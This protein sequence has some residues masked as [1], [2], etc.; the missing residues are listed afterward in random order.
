MTVNTR[1]VRYIKMHSQAGGAI[2]GRHPKSEK[3][4]RRRG[5]YIKMHSQA[6]GA[7]RERH[8]KSEKLPSREPSARGGAEK[9][10]GGLYL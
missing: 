5:R 1:A 4:R 7:I 10:G 6:G 8:P 2:R 9:G 3:R